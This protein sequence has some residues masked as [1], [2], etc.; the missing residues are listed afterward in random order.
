MNGNAAG[1]I[2]PIELSDST[3]AGRKKASPYLPE[4]SVRGDRVKWHN[5][6]A[7]DL[8]IDF[9]SQATWPFVGRY[10]LIRVPAGS[11]STEYTARPDGSL[12]GY[13]YRVLDLDGNP[14]NETTG[15]PGDP[16]VLLD[17]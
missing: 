14:L 11:A 3:Q 5:T 2:V 17:T 16:G 12:I 9:E 1:K 4:V 6:G 13:T 10:R 8:D 7:I 15:G